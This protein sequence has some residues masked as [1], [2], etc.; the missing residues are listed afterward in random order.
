MN[1]VLEYHSPPGFAHKKWLATRKHASSLEISLDIGSPC[2]A[3]ASPEG[4]HFD[5]A[6]MGDFA[7]G[8]VQIAVNNAV[9]VRVSI[10]K[11]AAGGTLVDSRPQSAPLTNWQEGQITLKSQLVAV[12]L[13]TRTSALRCD[14]EDQMVM[15]CSGPGFGCD[16]GD[17]PAK[18][19]VCGA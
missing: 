16:R 9:V 18:S 3:L 4:E 13:P 11:D 17:G 19:E 5:L 12:A 2:S 15:D 6:V 14:C 7:V 1:L 8:W 10:H